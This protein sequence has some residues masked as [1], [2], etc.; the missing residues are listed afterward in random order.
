MQEP[1][2]RVRE[3]RESY[4][5]KN[6]KRRINESMVMIYGCKSLKLPVYH[7]IMALKP[8]IAGIIPQKILMNYH[9]YKF[10]IS[11]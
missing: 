2:Y 7:Y 3:D 4:K 6:I 1:L 8:I 9:K 5:R 11:S 10:K